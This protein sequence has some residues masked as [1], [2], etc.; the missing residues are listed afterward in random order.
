MLLEIPGI[1]ARPQIDKIR[2]LAAGASF[3]DGRMSAGK[4]AARVKHNQELD[5]EPDRQQLLNR[6]I[7]SS[8]A[9]NSLFRSFALPHRMADFILARYEPGM[10]YGDHVDDPI[11]GGGGPRFRTDVSMT[12]FLN[13][14]GRY[15]GGELVVRTPFGDKP[16]K[17][18]AGSAVVYPSAS[19]HRVAPVIR[20]ERLV[21][22]TWMRSYVRDAAR[23]ELLFELDRAREHLLSSDPDADTTKYVDRSYANL[24][25]MWAEL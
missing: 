6:I 18:P 16:V 23:R 22:L 5:A 21:A 9:H 7:M 15:E 3:K 1:L 14:P 20:G 19:V 12:V 10:T 2:E 8:V 13:E 11:M 4:A 25:R 17:L 24:L